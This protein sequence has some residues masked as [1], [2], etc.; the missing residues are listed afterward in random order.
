VCA[1]LAPQECEHVARGCVAPAVAA[2]QSDGPF[3]DDEQ[4]FA[5][6]VV[7]EVHRLARR[8]LVD[9]Q[10]QVLGAGGFGEPRPPV[11]RCGGEARYSGPEIRIDAERRRPLGAVVGRL[12]LAGEREQR[13]LVELA[14]LSVL[15]EVDRI[16]AKTSASS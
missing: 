7:M 16:S 4:F 8:E 5:L 11:A 14:H 3:R 2:P 6:Q 13:A 9:R 1:A 12:V 10:A 15:G